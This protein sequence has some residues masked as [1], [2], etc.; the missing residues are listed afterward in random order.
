[1]NQKNFSRI[2]RLPPYVF[3]V[4]GEMKSMARKR[5]EDI[6]D[7]SM[8]NPDQ[9]TPKHIVRK[10][11]EVASK[12]HTHGYSASKGILRLRKAVCEW[13][14]KRYSV[15]ICKET[16]AI[17]TIGSKE[18]LAHL[19]LATLDRGDTILVPNPSYP[20][21]IYGAIIAGADV[22][23]VKM[24]TGEEFFS[25][26]ERAIAESIPK[27]KMIILGFPSNPTGEC[28]DLRF[29]EKVIALAKKHDIFVV[30]DLAYADICFDGYKAPSILQVG[31]A[32][33]YA[34]EFF[35]MSKSYN[36]AGWRVG[37]MVGNANLVSA[38]AKIKSYFDYGTFTPIQV[39]AVV[40]LES[41]DNYVSS[42]SETYQ[43]RRDTLVSGLNAIGWENAIPKATMYLWAKI[44]EPF[45]SEGSLSFSKRLLSEAKVAVSP[46]IGFGQYGEGFIRFALIENHQRI[47]QAIRGI[48]EMFKKAGINVNENH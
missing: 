4:I 37:F 26:L 48:R 17:V 34:V 25:E 5:G 45:M 10:L 22:R 2:E 35:S 16:E 18:G 28:V 23:S 29:F 33:D 38:L 19:M 20:I 1:M 7:M 36:M 9:P 6:I 46:G 30:H 27:P 3:S 24:T 32:K 44:P 15:A 8:G 39:A 47:K 43:A 13:Y 31:G 41:E 42:I 11:N 12:E 21:H 40:A 14:K